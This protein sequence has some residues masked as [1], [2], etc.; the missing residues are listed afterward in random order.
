M[1]GKLR[2]FAALAITM[3]LVVGVGAVG[4]ATNS[5]SNAFAGTWSRTDYPV[6][7]GAASR[8]WLWGPKAETPVMNEAY[9]DS[10][11]GE[12]QVQ[13]YDKARMEVTQ[14]NGDASSTWY[15]TSGLLAK[16][17]VTGKMQ[18][19]ND[20]FETRQ[21]A[22]I[23]V[24]G[25]LSDPNS[26]TYASFTG[27]LD[28]STHDPGWII[29][30]VVQRDGSVHTNNTF[31]DKYHVPM[32]VT[33]PE[34]GHGV[35]APFWDFMTSSGTIWDGSN[36][37]QGRL[38]PNAFYATGLPITE[39][40]W[41]SVKLGGAE[42]DVLVQVF[43]RR[44]L[45][46][47]PSNPSGW[48]VESSNVGLHYYTWRY[49]AY[50]PDSSSGANGSSAVPHF[51]HVYLI[52]MENKE[53]GSIVGNSDAPFLNS[54]IDQNGLATNYT[55]IVHPSQPNY[56]ALWSGSIY[57]VFDNETHHLSGTTI[58]DQLDAAGKSWMVYEENYPISSG[59]PSCY[60]GDT[61]TGGPDGPGTYAGKH[62]PELSF[63]DP[64][65][66]AQK[67]ANHITN[68]SHFMAND[69]D[70]NLIVP[71]LCNDMH[72][73]SISEGDTW[74]NNWLTHSI[75]QTDAWNQSDSAIFI[76]WDEGSTDKSGGGQ[77]PTIVISRHTPKGFKS[78]Q[79]ANHFT[80]LRT[81]EE[82]FG[83]GCLQ[84]SCNHGDLSQF[85]TGGANS[86]QSSAVPG[87][88]S[89]SIFMSAWRYLGKLPD[90]FGL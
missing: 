60:M 39:P 53:Y 44:V 6:S 59:T 45:T 4:A 8:T 27:L 69:A 37:V 11:N 36:Y 76:T 40:Y 48:Q 79:P 23:D 55:A 31:A 32:A 90:Q 50:W 34:T 85:F 28:Q 66:D 2:M 1:V 20:S 87:D 33:A 7:T 9:S 47:T 81:I 77:V 25:D 62:N 16:E 30:Q 12:R 3:I 70:F 88:S 14:P 72:S 57:N 21:P 78:D 73:C 58:A 19:G 18:V 24:A 83:L 13:Y 46:Y 43:E 35:A 22:T 84:E 51:D 5:A 61:A 89:R 71:N 80:L 10:P 86:A 49:G 74:L 26:P 42:T 29:D 56:L 82:S 54:L 41:T 17:M 67:C 63:V 64:Q 75:L 15:V 38:F 52:V 68:L 65:K